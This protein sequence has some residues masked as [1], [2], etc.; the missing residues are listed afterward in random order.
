[1]KFSKII[2]GALI[3]D[4]VVGDHQWNDYWLLWIKSKDAGH[5]DEII[6]CDTVDSY[7]HTIWL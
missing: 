1:M 3:T 7:W 4:E 6:D 2:D 5:L